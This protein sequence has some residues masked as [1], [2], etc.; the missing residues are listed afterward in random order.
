MKVVHLSLSN[1]GGAGIAAYRLHTALRESGVDSLMLTLYSK[2]DDP[3]V[4]VIN[5]TDRPCLSSGPGISP[6]YYIHQQRQHSL[7]K[8]HPHRQT[9]RALFT[10]ASSDVVL[11]D[12]S[13]IREASIIHLHWVAGIVDYSRLAGDL[14]GKPVIL[15]MHGMNDFTGGCHHA[16]ECTRYQTTCINCPQLGDHPFDHAN[17]YFLQK[18]HGM[19]SLDLTA[20]S[21][22]KWLKELALKSTILAGREILH[23]PNGVP[24]ETFKRLDADEA[25]RFFGISAD[26]HVLLFGAFDFSNHRKG[27]DLLMEALHRMP[28]TIIS[29]IT[30]AGYGASSDN[31]PASFPCHY[32]GIGP[33]CD[34]DNL[35]L[36]YSMADLFVMP[37]RAENLPNSILEALSC[38]TPVAAFAIG[39]IPEL[40]KHGV[41]GYLASPFDVQELADGI[42]WCLENRSNI[43]PETCSAIIRDHFTSKAQATA[44]TRLY[45]RLLST[46]PETADL[47]ATS[48]PPTRISRLAAFIDRIT[49]E[50]YPEP[51]S[52]LHSNITTRAIDHLFSAYSVPHGALVLDVGC[53]QGVALQHFI[54]RGCRPV[55]ITLSDEDLNVCRKQNYT[56]ARMDQSFLEFDDATFYIVWARHVAEHSIFPYY[57]LTEFNRVLKPGGI[58]YIEVPAAETT[59]LH[60]QNSNHYSILSRTMWLSL[61]ERSGFMLLEDQRYFLKNDTG[62]DEYWA[63]FGQKAFTVFS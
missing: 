35:A 5:T 48:T 22:S 20:V 52:P 13:E 25:K 29:R 4:K 59:C 3:T 45:Q 21:P 41:N 37:S 11:T 42:M 12:I 16:D 56:V 31:Q 19:N 43:K 30:I 39:G 46:G 9:D 24:E 1:D 38:G 6:H 49:P 58:I 18:L 54:A 14:K 51:T 63:F 26:Q 17:Y 36:L 27:L 53:G 32:R 33:V 57:T 40:V 61:M 34:E 47:M 10:D 62:P 2:N 44:Y 7:M 23:I 8:C 60:E 28:Q 15:T 50:A 55:G